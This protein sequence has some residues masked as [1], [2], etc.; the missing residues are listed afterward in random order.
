MYKDI[1]TSTSTWR[2]PFA[3]AASEFAVAR[4]RSLWQWVDQITRLAP[5]TCEANHITEQRARPVHY[6]AIANIVWCTAYT[7]GVGWGSDIAY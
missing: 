6:S 4:P 1:Y 2:A 3:T 5:L 7:R